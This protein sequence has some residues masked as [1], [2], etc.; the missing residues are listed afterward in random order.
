MKTL[1]SLLFISFFFLFG[2]AMAADT[3][4]ICLQDELGEMV[5]L[6]VHQ[7]GLVLGYSE[8]AFPEGLETAG[9]AFGSF[10]RLAYPE[11]MIGGDVNNDCTLGLFPGKL[12][13]IINVE[14]LE[15]SANGVLFLCDPA[16]PIERVIPFV[17]KLVPCPDDV[18]PAA[19]WRLF[20]E[21]E[22][23]DDD[24]DDDDD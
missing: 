9:T 6:N 16:S 24:D 12:N 5:H 17:S 3:F 8:F 1:A 23:G 13:A 19:N 18:V 15:G 22:D 10:R 4:E 2:V 7:S 21:R 11:V 20:F 14:T